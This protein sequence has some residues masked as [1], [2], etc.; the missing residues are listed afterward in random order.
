MMSGFG[1]PIL[2]LFTSD[3]SIASSSARAYVLTDH[4]RQP[5]EIQYETIE[6]SSRMAN[7]TMRRFITANKKKIAVS[8]DNVPAAGGYNFTADA[9]LGAAWLKSFYEENIYNPVWIKLTYAEESWRFAG[10]QTVAPNDRYSSTNQTFNRTNENANTGNPN[11]FTIST[12][13]F[14]AFS[15][16]VGTASLTTSAPH[17]FSAG[18]EIYVSGVDQIFNGTWIIDQIPSPN[19]L[20][21]KFNSANNFP[22]NFNINSYVQNGSS[23]TFN[24]DNTSFIKNNATFYVSGAKS[25]SGS[26]INGLWQVTSSPTSNTSFTASWAGGSQT[27]A[28]GQYGTATIVSS[29]ALATT[30]VPT[31]NPAVVGP[32]VSS[33][34]LKVFI[35]NFSYNI[36][37]R[38]TL[39]DYVNMS[40]E[41]TEI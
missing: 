30:S 10:K 31:I 22:A 12:K 13:A 6:N 33:D 34:I 19:S 18:T 23:A 5:L 3:P 26:V 17:T 21:F 29:T 28:I 35:S 27:N 24:V 14:S 37:H 36:V 9:N 8:W 25:N 2:Q 32:A 4:N 40:I 20:T 41:F 15:A 7:G 1:I 39:T 16:S 38:L 11:T